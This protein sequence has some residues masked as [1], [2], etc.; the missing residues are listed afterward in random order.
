MDFSAKVSDWQ[1]CIIGDIG[2]GVIIAAGAYWVDFFSP[3]AGTDASARFRFYGVGFGLGGN[4][5]SFAL[6]GVVPNIWSA[7]PA[8]RP[9][10]VWE[11]NG[12]SGAI[13]NASAG[14]GATVGQTNMMA[15]I[16]SDELFNFDGDVGLSGGFGAGISGLSGTWGLIGSVANIPP[17][18]V[19]D[20]SMA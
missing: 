14:V 17:N 2:A 13:G 18:Y 1:I 12:A 7:L 11:L 4:L 10:S 19:V 6:P 16:G 20:P 5:S 3:T 15:N 9:F 8:E